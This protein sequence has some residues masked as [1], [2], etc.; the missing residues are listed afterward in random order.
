M[1]KKIT[2]ERLAAMESI[3]KYAEEQDIF[4]DVMESMVNPLHLSE[5]CEE[6]RRSWAEIEELQK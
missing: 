4:V 1:R 2:P 3:A 6:I 5:A